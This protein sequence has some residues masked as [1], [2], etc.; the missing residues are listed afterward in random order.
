ME[1]D[2]SIADE[3]L[4]KK[5]KKSTKEKKFMPRIEPTPI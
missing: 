1:L 2:I 4:I 3:N 5:I